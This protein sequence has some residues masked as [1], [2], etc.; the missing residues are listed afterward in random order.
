MVSLASDPVDPDKVYAAVGTY[1]NSWDPTNGAVL[2]SADRGASRRKAD[3]PVK[4]GGNMPGRGMGERLAIDPN[5]NKNTQP[6]AF[7]L[8]GKPCA[9]G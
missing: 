9:A 6:A 7:T 1:T 5:R 3:L 8:G 2:R 4:L